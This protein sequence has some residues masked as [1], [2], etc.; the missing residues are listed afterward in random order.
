[1]TPRIPVKINRRFGEMYCVHVEG[2]RVSQGLFL[3]GFF[4]DIL[5]DL[6]DGGSKFFQNVA[7]LC[8]PLLFP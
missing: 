5:Y 1:V 4:H 6:E 2:Q 8:V 3:D 7:G